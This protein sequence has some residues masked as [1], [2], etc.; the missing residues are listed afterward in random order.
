[1]TQNSNVA[2]RGFGF[3]MEGTVINVE[4]AHHNAWIKAAAEIGVFLSIDA[5][6]DQL[7]HFIGG[8]DEP[9]IREIFAKAKINPAPQQIALFLERKHH[10]YDEIV[11]EIDLS[12]RPGF[13]EFLNEAR[14]QGLQTSIGTA[15]DLE[16]G[17]VL[18]RRSGLDRLFMFDKIVLV[19]DVRKTKPAPDCFI[20]TAKV[21]G[22]HPSEQIVFE[23]SPRGVASGVAA[24]SRVVGMPIYNHEASLNRLIQA[25]ADPIFLDWRDIRIDDLLTP[26]NGQ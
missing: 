22:I 17:I 23:D 7:P 15:V 4:P 8:P 2:V 25:G 6:I 1:M 18:L 16:K 14:S 5:A 3:D 20:Q 12:P 9:L 26:T 21:M 10:F 19:T 11:Q 24:G 13:L